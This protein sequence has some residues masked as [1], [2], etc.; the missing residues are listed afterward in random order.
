M[1]AAAP[2]LKVLLVDDDALVLRSFERVLSRQH[3]VTVA[4]DAE[5]ARAL[6]AATTFDVVV[7]DHTMPGE[8]G[9]ALLQHVAASAPGTRRVMVTGHAS[10]EVHEAANRGDLHALLDKPVGLQDLL[11]A[12]RGG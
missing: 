2:R 11:A 7:S 1:A 3:D 4:C 6:L 5:R 8:S 12:V 10:A 9:L